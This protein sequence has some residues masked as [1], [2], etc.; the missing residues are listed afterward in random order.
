MKAIKTAL[1]RTQLRD[2]CNVFITSSV[3]ETCEL[4]QQLAQEWPYEEKETIVNLQKRSSKI[5]TDTIYANML[6][7]IPG[8]SLTI[9]ENIKVKYPN[10]S[11]L[12][13]VTKSETALKELQT[14]DKIGKKTAE[15]IIAAF[16]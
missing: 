8:I 4:L 14:I 13:E 3:T 16:Q 5:T 6:C 2:K 12:A 7:C 11:S 10:M 1:L 9:F 15:S